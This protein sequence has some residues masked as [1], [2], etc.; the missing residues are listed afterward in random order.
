MERKFSRKSFI[1]MQNYY[2]LLQIA[3]MINQ[4]VERSRQIV[5]IMSEHSKQTII[6]L[7]QKMIAYLTIFQCE[8][9]NPLPCQ[10]G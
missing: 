1:A 3:H 10:P 2:Q 6:D 7:W 5:E 9:I 4:L 8:W